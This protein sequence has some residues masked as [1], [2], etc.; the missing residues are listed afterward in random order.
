MISGAA[1]SA[2]IPL[3]TH[4][5]TAARLIQTPKQNGGGVVLFVRRLFLLLCAVCAFGFGGAAV[6][7][8][9]DNDNNN[10]G[11]GVLLLR[12]FWSQ[13]PAASV[14][15]RQRVYDDDGELLS[16]GGG[17]FWFARGGRF[18][19]EYQSPDELLLVSNGESFWSY[20]K[21]LQQVVVR[22]LASLGGGFLAALSA[23]EWRAL[24][25]LYNLSDGDVV[26][27]MHRVLAQSRNDEDSVRN[28]VFWFDGGGGLRRLDM[29]DAFGGIVKVDIRALSI[30]ADD[31]AFVFVPPPD[32]EVISDR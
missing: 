21:D 29:L 26:D 2:K 27:D 20:E 13:T 8:D 11:D 10:G 30:G 15:F 23:G 12:K 7:A 24:L 6:A 5:N 28:I 31:D 17:K 25:Q 1:R 4:S 19:V 32:A 16:D 3:M 18:R 22:P 9:D 14:A